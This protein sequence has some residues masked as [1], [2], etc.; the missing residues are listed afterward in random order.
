MGIKGF[1]ESDVEEAALQWLEEL[2]YEVDS[3]SNLI[4]V[5]KE[6]KSYEDIILKDRLLDALASLNPKIS[7]P[8]LE[9]A[10]REIL[11]PKQ[12]SLLENNRSFHKMI[13]DGVSVSY[14]DKDNSL[15]H[16]QLR[17]FDFDIPNNN[18][19]LAVNQFTVVENRVEKRPDIVV[20]VNGMP[21]VVFELNS[22]SD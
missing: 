21:L 7:R 18:N 4:D 14:H 22:A 5:T 3:G 10:L 8:V 13:T 16:T 9:D 17:L 20:F 1:I 11:I 6:R 12:V 15:K 19:F 2:H